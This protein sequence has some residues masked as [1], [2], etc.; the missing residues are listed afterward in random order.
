MRETFRVRYVCC[1]YNT[2]LE[3]VFVE[4]HS[5]LLSKTSIEILPAGSFPDFPKFS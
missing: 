3:R 5:T 4:K 1:I 2:R